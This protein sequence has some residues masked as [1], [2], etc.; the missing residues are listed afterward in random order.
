MDVEGSDL[1]VYG[2]RDVFRAE[3]FHDSKWLRERLH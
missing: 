1:E 2:W 3:A